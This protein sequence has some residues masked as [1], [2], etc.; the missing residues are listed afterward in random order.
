MFVVDGRLDVAQR[1]LPA[2]NR[3]KI[4]AKEEEQRALV[5]KSHPVKVPLLQVRA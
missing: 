2:S 5:S 4:A 1:D 3:S